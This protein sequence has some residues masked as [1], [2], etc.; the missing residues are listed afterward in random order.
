MIRHEQWIQTIDDCSYRSTHVNAI[1]MSSGVKQL[2]QELTTARLDG[3]TSITGWILVNEQR[4]EHVIVSFD[5]AVF[6]NEIH[7]YQTNKFDCVVKLELFESE[8]SRSRL[9]ERQHAFRRLF[10][11]NGGQCGNAHRQRTTR[12]PLIARYSSLSY[13]DII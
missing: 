6:I 9:N 5:K 3:D 2:C 12:N 11:I 8:R 4:Q 13:D 1:S 10:E 7:V